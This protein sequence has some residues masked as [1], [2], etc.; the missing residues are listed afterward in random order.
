M[1]TNVTS[2]GERLKQ[3][4][5]QEGLRQSDIVELCKPFAKRYG[6]PITKSDISSY[7]TG[8]SDPS[9]K[10]LFILAQALHVSEA[11]LMGLDVAKEPRNTISDAKKDIDLLSKFNSLKKRDQLLVTQII[12]ILLS[13]NDA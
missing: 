1:N 3:L 13:A 2:S 8:R 10:K 4:M 7:C 9:Q 11:W 6:V 5:A 12:D